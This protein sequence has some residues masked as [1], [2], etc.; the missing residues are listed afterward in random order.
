[1]PPGSRGGSGDR[2]PQLRITKAGDPM[3]RRL[4]VTS[5][6]DILGPFGPDTF[7]VTD[8]VYQPLRQAA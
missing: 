8:V 1:M 7:W 2:S 6:H 4:L 3:L 5:A